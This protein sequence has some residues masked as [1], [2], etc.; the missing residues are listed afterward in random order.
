MTIESNAFI[1]LG[2]LANH[3]D[4]AGENNIPTQA[5]IAATYWLGAEERYGEVRTPWP[6]VDDETRG[7]I[8]NAIT[9]VGPD[10]VPN[11]VARLRDVGEAGRLRHQLRALVWCWNANHAEDEDQ[12]DAARDVRAQCIRDLVDIIDAPA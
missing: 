12:S 7:W 10:P 9:T 5:V 8:I 4:H 1:R 11:A 6:D 3:A 2:M